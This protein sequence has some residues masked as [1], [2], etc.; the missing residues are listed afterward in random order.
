[1]QKSFFLELVVGLFRFRN[2]I[3]HDSPQ[4]VG[5]LFTL[6]YTKASCYVYAS[7]VDSIP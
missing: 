6:Q 5:P 7:V 2:A 1:M 3:E 4:D